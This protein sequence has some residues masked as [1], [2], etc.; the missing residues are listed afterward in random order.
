M[1]T[2]EMTEIHTDHISTAEDRRSFSSRRRDRRPMNTLFRAVRARRRSGAFRPR[3]FGPGGGHIA[4][5]L[6]L[7]VW[8]GNG[9]AL[10]GESDAVDAM[11]GFLVGRGAGEGN[12]WHCPLS[13][14][15]RGPAVLFEFSHAGITR[16]ETYPAEGAA[17]V[18]LLRPRELPYELVP[19]TSAGGEPRFELVFVHPP[20]AG[21]EGGRWLRP[22]TAVMLPEPTT[23]PA[24]IVTRV[25]A[26]PTALLA[27]DLATA[28]F[29]LP[30]GRRIMRADV[31]VYCVR[32]RD[33]TAV[34]RALQ[35]T[36]YP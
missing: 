30:D 34:R 33:L 24:E 6:L 14:D 3:F 11:R 19:A 18:F 13:G 15:Y 7:L 36:T 8:P 20:P 25:Q 31:S 27:V 26:D 5:G 29:R 22:V 1:R 17:R 32:Y 10:R 2:P 12:F 35:R 28:A 23:W 4:L 16:Y 21:P 9:P